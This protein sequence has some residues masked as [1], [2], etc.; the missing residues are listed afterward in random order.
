M[1]GKVAEPSSNTTSVPIAGENPSGQAQNIESDEF[2]N[3]STSLGST[4]SGEDQDNAL[5]AVRTKP[6]SDLTYCPDVDA[7]TA[8]EASSISK[9]SSGVLYGFSFSN[10]NASTRYI[11][12]FN[13][14]T[15]PADTSVP[16]AV[17]DCPAGKTIGV[18][19]P[20]G[21]PFSTGLC[22]CNSS[23]MNTKTIGS[24]DSLANVNFK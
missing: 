6:I 12:F 16:F 7:S 14:T 21:L 18:S 9:A 20:E 2:G 24:A 19:W 10:G 22:W 15:I 3:L 23:T 8:A 1:S 11:Q 4:L 13:S 5:F 17:F